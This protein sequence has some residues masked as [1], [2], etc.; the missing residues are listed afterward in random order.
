M[1]YDLSNLKILSGSTLK[2][3]AI[4]S[5]TID[6]VAL[7][8][9]ARHLS[10]QDVWLYDVL[11]GIGRL[12]FP[13]FALLVIEGFFNTHNIVRYMATLLIFALL[14]E[15]PWYLLGQCGSHNVLFTLLLG[16][17]A[18]YL[19][20]RISKNCWLLFIPSLCM[21]ALATW[22][23]TDYSW[24]GIGLMMVFYLFHEKPFPY[25]LIGLPFLMEYGIIGTCMG[26][27][28]C[29]LYNGNRGFI[30]G[31]WLKY[32]FYLYYPL[33]LITIWLFLKEQ[34]L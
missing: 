12:A 9:L 14:S 24:H 7:Y 3:I 18:V 28:V 33:H 20:D 27:L 21:A 8:V 25:Y 2:V 30:R 1:N 29:L 34:F 19:T 13:I 16:L 5:M 22:I 10:M 11:R 31:K 23:N 4:I 32:C 26:I 15:I 17:I 6:H